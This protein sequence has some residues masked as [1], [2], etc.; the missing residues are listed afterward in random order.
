M[1]DPCMNKGNCTSN[2]NGFTCECKTGHTG[3][4]CEKTVTNCQWG[5]WTLGECSRRCG[6]GTR[7]NTRKRIVEEANGGTCVGEPSMTE[8]CNIDECTDHCSGT[9]CASGFTLF[10]KDGH[11][12][13]LCGI[14]KDKAEY[15][16]GTSN[17]C[18]NNICVC[19]NHMEDNRNAA[20]SIISVYRACLTTDSKPANPTDT[21]ATCQCSQDSCIRSNALDKQIIKPFCGNSSSEVGDNKVEIGKCGKCQVT[22]TGGGG[23]SECNIANARRSIKCPY[24]STSCGPNMVCC[25]TGECAPSGFKCLT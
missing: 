21:S 6:K 3:K 18:L 22:S 12:Q 20:C 14:D 8:N 1:G 5:N 4:T 19:G 17:R 24:S 25:S 2:E 16:N 10:Y 11:C 9:T 7:T 23:A 13:C 15:C